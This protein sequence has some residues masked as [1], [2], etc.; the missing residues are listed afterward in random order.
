[1]PAKRADLLT[2]VARIGADPT[3]DEDLRLRKSLAVLVVLMILPVSLIWGSVY[4]IL[5]SV[6]GYVPF[7]YFVIALGGLLI[8]AETHDFG[9]FLNIQLADILLA[10]TLSAIPLGGFVA[11]SGV[12]LWG[13]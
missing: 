11:S 2:R 6:V 3:D 13:V 5:G 4:L 1:M 12:G 8:F 9:L 7:V 10:P